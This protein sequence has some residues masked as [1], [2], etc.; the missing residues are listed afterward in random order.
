MVKFREENIERERENG[1]MNG[2]GWMMEKNVLN[3]L[4]F[5]FFKKIAQAD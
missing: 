3:A 2:P 1:W 4:F 5:F